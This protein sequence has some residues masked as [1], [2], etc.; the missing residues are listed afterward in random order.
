[1][2]RPGPCGL[3]EI[4][5]S[6]WGKLQGLNVREWGDWLLGRGQDAIAQAG[7]EEGAESVWPLWWMGPRGRSQSRPRLGAGN[8]R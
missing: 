7:V 4:G 3:E 2:R 1:M 8:R 5:C 6:S